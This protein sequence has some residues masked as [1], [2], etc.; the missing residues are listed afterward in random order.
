MVRIG[1][2]LGMALNMNRSSLLLANENITFTSPISVKTT[3]LPAFLSP[4]SKRRQLIL[5]DLPRLITVKEENRT[6][7][8]THPG[9]SRPDQSPGTP[10]GL[11]VKS[12]CVF[13]ARPSAGTGISS[14]SETSRMGSDSPYAVGGVPRSEMAHDSGSGGVNKVVDVVEKGARGFIVQTVSF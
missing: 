6:L 14:L 13:V 4:A 11:S 9:A 1:W 7:S 8:S 2:N 10:S 5:T 3:S 12:E